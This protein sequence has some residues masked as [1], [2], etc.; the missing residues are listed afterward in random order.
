[1][2]RNLA[3]WAISSADFIWNLIL[4]VASSVRANRTR[5]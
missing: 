3:S 2:G 1:M 5:R 4:V